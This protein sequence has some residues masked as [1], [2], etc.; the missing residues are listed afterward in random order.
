MLLDGG[1]FSDNPT[2]DGD[3]RTRAVL[4]GMALL[5]YGAVGVGERDVSLGYDEFLKRTQGI[6]LTFVSTNLVRQDTK[7]PVFEPYAVIQASAR[8]GKAP[9]RIGVL[10][11]IRYNPMFRKAGPE[12]TNLAIAPPTEMIRRYIG[13]V[14]ESSDV[15]VLLASLHKDDARQIARDVPGIDYVFGSYGGIYSAQVETEGET[16]LLYTGNQ[17]KRIADARVFLGADRKIA[18][19]TDYLYFLTARY[20]DEPAMLEWVGKA[21]E[22]IARARGLA[23]PEPT[24]PAGDPSRP[25]LRTPR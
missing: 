6:D 17:G 12:G 10:S 15:V 9:V 25:G 24:V 20:P 1:N 23:S 4:E 3:A 14:R 7:E 5:G 13:K 8:P 16:R 11:V 2:P 22:R 21:L 18:A 19:R